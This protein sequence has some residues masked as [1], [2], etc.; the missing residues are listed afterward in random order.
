MTLLV[1]QSKAL[2]RLDRSLLVDTRVRIASS[3]RHLNPA[4]GIAGASDD[5]PQQPAKPRTPLYIARWDRAPHRQDEGDEGRR[6][7]G[8]SLKPT[9][10]VADP[11]NVRSRTAVRRGDEPPQRVGS[12]EQA[13]RLMMAAATKGGK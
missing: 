3:G 12:H 4:W 11:G 2:C 5:E 6:T 8:V 9:V 13:D 1:A 7:S 10:G